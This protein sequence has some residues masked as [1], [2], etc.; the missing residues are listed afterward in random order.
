[1]LRSICGG[2]RHSSPDRWWLGLVVARSSK[3]VSGT[4]GVT[5][6]RLDLRAIPTNEPKFVS[7]NPETCELIEISLF[8][9]EG[10]VREGNFQY[11]PGIVFDAADHPA[12]GVTC[13]VLFLLLTCCTK[14]PKCAVYIS[15]STQSQPTWLL[16]V[17]NDTALVPIQTLRVLL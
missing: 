3:N 7:S 9:N 13:L 17:L 15:S 6:R 8:Q 4:A 10:W 5:Q 14:T 2:G 1:M 16:N 12:P 11:Y